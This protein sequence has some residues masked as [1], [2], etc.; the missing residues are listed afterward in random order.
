MR[1]RPLLY[2]S[3]AIEPHRQEYQD[4]LLH[5]SQ[6][7]DWDAWMRF[8]LRAVGEAADD[9]LSRGNRLVDLQGRLDARYK[10]RGMVVALKLV[11]ELFV[12]PAFSIN[13]MAERSG[14]T[15]EALR[16]TVGR[17]IED[18]VLTEVTGQPRNRVYVASEIVQVLNPTQDR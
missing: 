6:T 14:V 4:G 10:D 9:A 18:N 3:S 5:Q 8:F 1:G 11:D 2:L 16:R 17:L 7:G 15:S 13:S 12:T